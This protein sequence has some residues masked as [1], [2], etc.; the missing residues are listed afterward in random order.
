MAAWHA[1]N[2]VIIDLNPGFPALQY[3]TAV[4]F[5]V[6][7]FGLLLHALGRFRGISVVCGG[8]AALGAVAVLAQYVT[9]SEMGFPLLLSRLPAAPGLAPHLP[10]PPTAVAFLLCGV[11][12]ALLGTRLHPS[13]L[14]LAI[15]GVGALGLTLSAMVLVGYASGLP[16]IYVWGDEIGM[17]PHTAAGV[18][19][20]NLGLLG[21][22][23]RRGRSILDDRWLPVPAAL[24]MVATTVLLWQAIV[25]ERQKFLQDRAETVAQ[26]LAATASVRLAGSVR[27]LERMKARW[28]RRGGTPREEWD[29]DA[30]AYLRD[31]HILASIEWVDAD[32]RIQWMQPPALETLRQGEDIRSDTSWPA[33][34]SLEQAKRTRA[35]E[36]PPRV[37][38]ATGGE[39]YKIC[40]PLFSES[41]FDGFLIATVRLQNLVSE[42]LGERWFADYSISVFE[43]NSLVAGS[44]T[45]PAGARLSATATLDFRGHPWRFV[46]V[47]RAS[48]FDGLNLATLVLGLGALL[49]LTLAAAVRAHQLTAW[50]GH[51]L[52]AANDQLTHEIAERQAAERRLRDSEERLRIVLASATGISVVSTDLSGTITFFS[53]GSEHMLGYSASEMVARQT[54]LAFHDPGEV[55]ERAAQLTAELG[56]TVEGFETLVAVSRLRGSEQREW[57]YVCKDGARR[58]VELTV[59]VLRDVAGHIVG[60][61]GTA[62]D[63]TERKKMEAGLQVATAR[64]EAQARAKAEFLANMSHEIRTPLNA[65]LGMSELLMDSSLDAHDRE[66]VETIHTSGDVLLS[67]ITDILDFSKIESGQ[68][69]FERIPVRLR[70]CVESALE[71][72]AAPAARKHIDLIAWI[73]PAVPTAILGDP[74]RLRQVLVNLLSNAIKFTE[75]GEV[76]VRVSLAGNDEAPRLHVAVRDS[77]IGIPADRIDRLFHAFSQVD[78]STTRRYGGTGLGLAISQR[79][80]QKMGGRIRV[81]SQPGVGSTFRF[82]IPFQPAGHPPEEESRPRD[83]DGLSVLIV[84]DNATCRMV[85]QMQVEAWGMR[86]TT[87]ATT[88]EALQALE[89]NPPFSLAILDAHLE[90]TDGHDLAE[91]IHLRLGKS[92]PPRL[93][94]T[95]LGEHP[96]HPAE[97]GISENI[98]KPAR[99]ASLFHAIRRLLG[100]EPASPPATSLERER[101]AD[102]HPLRILVAEDNPV[103]QRVILLLLRRLGYE[104]RIVNNGREL[105]NVLETES[106]DVLLIDVQMPEMD[107]LTA[108]QE[109]CHRYAEEQRPWMVALT[110]HAGEGDEATCLAA[111][112]Q[113]YLSKPLRSAQLEA[114]LTRAWHAT[115]SEVA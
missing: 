75:A 12:I 76:F 66:L 83:L 109:I 11:G 103:N 42:A 9:G 94:L 41:R 46:V 93:L 24:A 55:R 39:G 13:L 27:A 59:T 10:S 37:P 102:T 106:F 80:I 90:K 60:Y 110:A 56:H 74:T 16:E 43:E 49:A 48:A 38:L 6:C 53:R 104:P 68:V 70:D 14:R 17:A 51:E 69:E 22:L 84:D 114:A 105:L 33:A 100:Y 30:A 113:G 101:L 88:A 111:G 36:I 45:L 61:L 44:A 71:V 96:A 25:V 64:A 8:L 54:P 2:V 50:H 47:P 1:G 21:S 87:A 115:H 97:P 67:L 99:E 108:A 91:A 20:L 32:W 89:T 31:E 65:V 34:A 86:A 26:S 107:G 92:A 7:G 40:L 35:L 23:W 62:M 85:L 28:E 73:D 77:G 19:V 72:V 79:I 18:I 15:W 5:V 82:E 58:T 81:E 52:R 3:L 95:P 29:A 112:M 57:T 63:V 78:A 98:S 4:G